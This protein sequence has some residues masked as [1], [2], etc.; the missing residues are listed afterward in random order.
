M[1][2]LVTGA[3]LITGL[4]PAT[5]VSTRAVR[6]M[7]AA[8]GVSMSPRSVQRNLEKLRRRALV[9]RRGRGRDGYRWC[10]A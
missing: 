5:W 2:S 4:S 1:S 10:L 8:R 6:D 3:V 9:I 7:L